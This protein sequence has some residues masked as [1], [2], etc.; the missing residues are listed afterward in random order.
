VRSPRMEGGRVRGDTPFCVDGG[1]GYIRAF[2]EIW[3]FPVF[4]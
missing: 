3:S 1:G 4:Y 2:T